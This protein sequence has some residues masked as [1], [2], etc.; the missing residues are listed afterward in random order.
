MAAFIFQKITRKKYFRKV[1]VFVF[2]WN[3]FHCSLVFFPRRV[4]CIKWGLTKYLLTGLKI[5]VWAGKKF[6][7]HQ[8]QAYLFI[9]DEMKAWGMGMFRPRSQELIRYRPSV[10]TNAVAPL[11]MCI[12]QVSQSHY[13]SLLI[14]TITMEAGE[15]RHYQSFWFFTNKEIE[16]QKKQVKSLNYLIRLFHK[17]WLSPFCGPRTVLVLL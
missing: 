2:L 4:F 16:A 5:L 6:R 17:Y 15:H 1:I 12:T 13:L 10:I 14:L 11:I 8:V 3:L 9:D 7:D